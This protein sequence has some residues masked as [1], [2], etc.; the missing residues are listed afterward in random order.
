MV[1]RKT[2]RKQYIKLVRVKAVSIPNKRFS[3]HFLKTDLTT[4]K[5]PNKI[6]IKEINPGKYP[7]PI[8]IA[9]P[10]A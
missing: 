2:P 9:V 6:R 4:I 7:G 3:I 5:N 1:P 10:A 8:F